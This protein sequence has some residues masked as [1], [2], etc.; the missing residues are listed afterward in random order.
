MGRKKQLKFRSGFERTVYDNAHGKLDY[1]PSSPVVSYSTTSRY[2]PDFALP[3]GVL[4]EAKGYFDVRA[5][6]KMLRVRRQNKDLDI[7]LVFQ[8]ANNRITKSPNSLMYW[9][10]AERHGFPWAEGQIP[11]GWWKE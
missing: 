11:E 3:N 10:W 8:R 5:R 9:Q 6:A 7:R 2:I 1:E 4:V